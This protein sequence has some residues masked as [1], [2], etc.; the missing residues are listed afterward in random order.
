MKTKKLLSFLLAVI[1]MVGCMGITASAEGETVTVSLLGEKQAIIGAEYEVVL[2]VNETTADSVGGIDCEVTYDKDKF[3]LTRIEISEQFA[4]ANKIATSDVSKLINT[5]VE[6][7]IR[8]MLLQVA[9]DGIDNNWITFVFTVKGE[10]ATGDAWFGITE[11]TELSNA[12]GTQ[13]LTRGLATSVTKNIFNETVKVNGASI[14]KD[15][16]GDIRFE[17]E[18]IDKTN[19]KEIGFIMLPTKAVNNGD[20]TIT[21]DGKYTMANG[22][23]ITLAK[24]STTVDKLTSSKK[25]YCYLENSAIQFSLDTSFSAR[26]YVKLEGD[27]YIYSDNI[28]VDNGIVGGTSSKSCIETAKAIIKMYKAQGKDVSSLETYLTA[29]VDTWKAN[30]KSIVTKLAELE[31]AN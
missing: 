10:A 24:A 15:G 12:Q 31:N 14:K 21:A 19:V 17:A 13:L 30:Y 25:M 22:N 8:V 6:G 2:N 28:I 29:D 11:E 20:M 4:G 5:S 18:I 26:A 16:N 9:N 3:T 27:T 7:K 1:L 23:T